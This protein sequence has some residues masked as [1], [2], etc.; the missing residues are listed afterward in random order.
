M[1]KQKEYPYWCEKCKE[2]TTNSNAII[3]I[4]KGVE[5]V[6]TC[7]TC[8]HRLIPMLEEDSGMPS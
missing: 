1:I 3:W 6:P 5:S 2:L 8:K 4:K 7:W